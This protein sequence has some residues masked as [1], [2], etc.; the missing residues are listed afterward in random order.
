MQNIVT[1]KIN[2]TSATPIN[3][4]G[5]APYNYKRKI[6]VF[7]LHLIAS[8]GAGRINISIDYSTQLFRESTIPLRNLFYRF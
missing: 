4:L 5:I 6:S 2:S 3:N 8:E 7:D 1:E